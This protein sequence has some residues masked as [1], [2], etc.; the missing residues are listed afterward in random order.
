MSTN[1]QLHQVKKATANTKQQRSLSQAHLARQIHPAAI[2][3]RA[4]TA[5]ESLSAADVLQLQ[6]TIGDRA[7]GQLMSEI[8]R[9]PPTNHQAPVQQQAPEKE[10]ELMQGKF[11]PIQFQGE[12]EDEEILQGKFASRLTGT[13]QAKE[14]APP[15]RTGMPDHLKSGLEYI[16]G[17]DLSGVRV[18]YNS[19]KPKQLNALAYTRGQEIH[20]APGQEK[21]LPHEGWHVVQQMQGRVKPT[22]QMK[23]VSI[24]NDAGMEHEA[25][26][27]G[28]KAM[29]MKG[30]ETNRDFSRPVESSSNVIQGYFAAFAE[31][32]KTYHIYVPEGTENDKKKYLKDKLKSTGFYTQTIEVIESTD[33]I[34]PKDNK[35][36][37]TDYLV[38]MEYETMTNIK[39]GNFDDSDLKSVEV[40]DVLPTYNP[41]YACVLQ[42]LV[43][44]KKTVFGK[45]TAKEL[46]NELFANKDYAKYK[47]YDLDDVY[48]TLYQ[49]AGLSVTKAEDEKLEYVVDKLPVNKYIFEV[50]PIQPGTSGHNFVISVNIKNRSK[51]WSVIQ[52]KENK[53][54]IT[55]KTKIRNYWK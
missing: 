3:Q 7:V 42:A 13:L 27:M 41:K 53:E 29:Q 15:N 11:D 25:D 5:P 50:T 51:I 46:H 44:L 21:Y 40:S 2:I 19:P 54:S 43:N 24:N 26:V 31:N 38:Y 1:N 35:V 14:V 30:T 17:M 6:C 45:N 49:A 23:G 55:D 8:G 52:D 10:E 34:P 16:S 33:K 47:E 9:L 37:D 36:P 48:P 20:V 18:H 32:Y 12:H 4:R 22:M 39:N 28:E